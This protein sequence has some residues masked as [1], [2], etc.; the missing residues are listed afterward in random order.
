MLINRPKARLAALPSALGEHGA[1]ADALAILHFTKILYFHTRHYTYKLTCSCTR[2]LFTFATGKRALYAAAAADNGAS[3]T[4]SV[5]PRA[6]AAARHPRPC[7]PTP[8]RASCHTL[9]AP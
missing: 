6:R 8:L 7:E 9:E 2:S 1:A 3:R 5:A 4:A